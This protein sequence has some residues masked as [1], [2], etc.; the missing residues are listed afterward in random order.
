MA[1]FPASVQFVHIENPLITYGALVMLYT[2]LIDVLNMGDEELDSLNNAFVDSI[3]AYGDTIYEPSYFADTLPYLPVVNYYDAFMGPGALPL[4]YV[5]M[6]VSSSALYLVPSMNPNT[7]GVAPVS[8]VHFSSL[9]SIVL[10]D[11]PCAA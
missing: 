2:L 9:C 6:P 3:D 11:L 10:L 8:L 1:L 7:I 4:Q 5:K